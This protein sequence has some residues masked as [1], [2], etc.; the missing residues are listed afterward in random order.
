M[1]RQQLEE[2]WLKKTAELK[3][4]REPL[5]A[6]ASARPQ[7]AK[8]EK[9]M[10]MSFKGDYKDWICFWNQYSVEVDGSAISIEDILEDIRGDIQRRYTL[11]TAYSGRIQ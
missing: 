7:S 10:I 1:Q 6:P 8:L 5:S 3:Q 4:D 11:T 9:Y 2:E